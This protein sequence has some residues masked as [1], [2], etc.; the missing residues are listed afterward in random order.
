MELFRRRGSGRLAE[1][2]GRDSLQD[3]IV[4]R[5]DYYTDAEVRRM[6]R[7]LPVRFQ[8]RTLA[9]VDGV[10]AHIRRVR[11]DRALLPPEFSALNVRLTDW[12]V[13]DTLRIGILLARTIP[14]GN[15]NELG[16]LDALRELGARRFDELLP[17]SVPGEI[18]TIPESAGTVPVDAPGAR[19][20][21][22]RP[23]SPG[24]SG[25]CAACR[26]P[27]EPPGFRPARRR[28]PRAID[29]ALGGVQGSF[30]WAIRRPSDRHTFFFNGTAARLPGPEHVPRA[31]SPDA[32][33][34]AA[35]R[36]RPRGFRSTPTATTPTSHGG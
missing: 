1:I 12:T 36:H 19:A 34:T 15:G 3:D 11:R 35:H 25:G 4:A 20:P 23:R 26:A 22:P 18:P 33:R 9:Y 6:F 21:R 2:L 16:N 24:R 29:V 14:S 30:M 31:R 5:R 28:R 10:N 7:R 27:P 17:L 13:L 32:R 8:R